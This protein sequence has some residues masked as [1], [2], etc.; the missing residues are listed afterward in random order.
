MR[1]RVGETVPLIGGQ[2]G[3]KRFRLGSDDGLVL[4]RW[5]MPA[6][7]EVR[8]MAR[9]SC[10]QGVRCSR[11]SRCRRSTRRECLS[12]MPWFPPPPPDAGGPGILTVRRTRKTQ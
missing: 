10:S 1:V 5:S 6:S 11:P 3:A 9:R 7:E 2:G 12:V 8:M 4:A